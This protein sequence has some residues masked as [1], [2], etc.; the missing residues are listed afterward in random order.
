MPSVSRPAFAPPGRAF[1]LL[2]GMLAAAFALQVAGEAG[3]PAAIGW[4]ESTLALTPAAW[5]EGEYWR[6][7]TYG[8][9]HS[10]TNLFHLGL[11]LA[12]VLGPGAALA[13][14][15]GPRL[16]LGAWVA[17][18]LL[19][20]LCWLGFHRQA[21]ELQGGSTAGAYALLAAYA[22][23]HP[24]RSLR[25]LVFFAV[26]LRL[27]PRPVLLALLGGEAFFLLIGEVLQRALPFAPAAS[28]HLGGA[29]AGWLVLRACRPAPPENPAPRPARLAQPRTVPA[30]DPRAELDRILDK[31][32]Q[33]GLGSL[34][35]A[36]RRSLAAARDRLS[37]R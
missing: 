13:R 9:I 2:A 31:I 21:G 11:V 37:R 19:G 27:R 3:W 14:E 35:P 24:E 1:P 30:L 5:S 23:R 25:L 18:Q 15:L 6:L 28:A 26:P 16:P 10:T 7:A 36:E 33:T 8:L 12:A 32:N 20:G 29:V 17:G 22:V 34:T 4:G